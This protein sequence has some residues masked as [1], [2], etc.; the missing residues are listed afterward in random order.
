MAEIEIRASDGGV[1]RAYVANQQQVT[2]PGLVLAHAMFGVSPQTRE[3]ADDLSLM[4]CTVV[5]PDLYSRIQPGTEL[6]YTDPAN[7]PKAAALLQRLDINLAIADLKATLVHMRSMKEIGGARIG[8]LGR[9]LGGKL[10]YLLMAR[11]DVDC[12][13]SF[14]GV[15]I[16]KLL[17]ELPNIRRPWL[18]IVA[19]N[20]KFVPPEAQAK[21]RAALAGH[22]Q[23]TMEVFAGRDHA[24]CD[25]GFPSYH[26]MDSRRANELGARFLDKH[27]RLIIPSTIAARGSVP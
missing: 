2:G 19:G 18:N 21:I 16:D 27:L 3:L 23:A 14:Y 17:D 4:G 8:A 24:F 11:S 13:V 9:C 12:G 6:D 25:V 5:C 7:V 15:D 26:P 10:V 1:F 22:P 20:D